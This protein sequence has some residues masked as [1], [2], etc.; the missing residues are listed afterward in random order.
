MHMVSKKD[1]SDVEMDILTKS[2]SP[3]IVIIAN[4][5]VQ[6][7]EEAIVYVRELDIFLFFESRRQHARNIVAW[8]F[9]IWTRIFLR[10]EQRSKTKS[11]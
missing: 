8:K 1:V 5:E 9:L 4:G 6:M 7:H 10:V 2:C 3:T 11:H